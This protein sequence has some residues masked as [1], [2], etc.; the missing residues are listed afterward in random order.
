M[1]LNIII[2]SNINLVS[3]FIVKLLI[4]FIN[5]LLFYI[6]YYIIVDTFRL[7]FTIFRSF[8][9]LSIY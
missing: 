3:Y 9:Y 1:S 7:Y 6:I 4:Y 8:I 2:V 5:N